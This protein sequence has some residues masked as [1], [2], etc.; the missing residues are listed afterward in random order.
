MMK[1]L[2]FFIIIFCQSAVF[3][4]SKFSIRTESGIYFKETRE[5]IFS[6]ASL[7]YLIKETEN[8][9]AYIHGGVGVET[10][11][12]DPGFLIPIYGSIETD[13]LCIVAGGEFINGSWCAIALAELHLFKGIRA[14]MGVRIDDYNEIIFGLCYNVRFG[15]K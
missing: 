4:Q 3:S 9:K 13:L 12:H 14:N 5:D 1:Y 7:S 11:E 10:G 8:Y 15:E 6:K 2:L